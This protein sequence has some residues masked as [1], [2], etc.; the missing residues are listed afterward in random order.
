MFRRPSL[1][2]IPRLG[3]LLWLRLALVLPGSAQTIVI[4]EVHYDPPEPTVRAEFVELHNPSTQSIPLAGWQLSGGIQFLFPNEARLE[5]GGF[6]VIGEHPATLAQ[7]WNVSAL[8]PWSGKLA[9]S[10]DSIELR[11]PTGRLVD[12]VDYQPGF[13]WP[14][15]GTDPGLS[16]ERIHPDLDGNLAG[17]WRASV[18]G[19]TT[20]T[21][22]N[23]VVEAGSEWRYRKGTPDAAA[24]V[25]Q[26]RTPDFSDSDW[27]PARLPIGYDA[28]VSFGTTLADMRGN[29]SSF[30]LRKSFEISD[31]SGISALE[32]H[33]LY[34]DGFKLWLNG[35]PLL[36]L[37]L[38]SREV[39]LSATAAGTRESN[40]YESLSVPLPAGLLRDGPNLLAVQ[41]HNV[42]LANSTDCFFDARVVT[43][44]GPTG[45]GPTP[46][47]TNL[48]YATNAPPAIRQVQH[49]PTQPRSGAPVTLS[50]RITDPDG[51]K[52]VTLAY[53]VV[54]PGNY[55]ELQDPDFETSWTFLPMLDD[56][57]GGDATA[58]D[59]L[60]TA[61]I[62]PPAQLH[63]TLV[64]YRI[65]ASDTHDQQVRVPYPDDPQPN[66]AYF[67]YDGAPAWSGSIRPGTTGTLGRTFTVSSNEMNRLP[68]VHL[69]A[70]R[71]A[72][73]ESTW[74][75]RYGGDAYLWNGTLVYDGQV[76]DHVRYR[77][78]GGVWRY[79]MT[80][81]MWKFDF[82]RGHSF[83]ARDDWGRRFPASWTKLNLGAS[84]QQ[85]DYNHRGEQGMFES[86]GFRIF[87]LAGVPAMNS[88][89]VQFRVID[90]AA[91]AIPGNQFEGDFWG[92]YLMLEQPDGRFLDSHDLPDGNLYKM[93]GGTG[94]LNNVGPD[95]PLDKS[96]LNQFL[97]A[98]SAADESWWR[99]HFE[100]TQFLG[101]QTV[102]QAI[103]HYDICYDK[104]FFY[105]LN[106]V[107]QRW[108]VIPW[109]LDLSWADN[110]FDPGCG[111]VD[112]IKQR[113]LPNPSRFPRVWR[114]WQNRIREFR[115]LFWNSDE[116]W[117]LIDEQAGRLRGPAP[118]GTPTVLDADRAQWDYN[119]KMVDPTYSSSPNSKAGHGR[120][121]R[122]PNYPESEVSRDFEGCLTLM[123]RYVGFR[124]TN[125][126]AQAR[127][128]D[129][130]A[131]DPALPPRPRLAY[132]GTPG[133]PV[134]ALRF[135]CS[136]P[137]SGPAIATTRWRIGAIT[138]PSLSGP[139]WQATEPWKYEITPVWESGP[140]DGFSPQTDI[141]PGALRVGET[142]RARVQFEDAEGRT[143][144][145]SEPIEFVAGPPDTAAALAASL[146]VTELMFHAP[147]GA[148]NDFLELYNAGDIP[149][150]L[151]GAT[152]SQ[153]IE[154]T[155]PT[156]AQLAPR[157][158]AL[159]SRASPTGNFAGFRT[160][161]GL[162]STVPIFGPYSGNFSDA[163]ETI[164][165]RDA[166]GGTDLIS[167]TYSDGR[168]WPIP[169]DGAGHSLV[170]RIDFGSAASGALDFGGN[171]RASA[172]ILGS[173]GRAD[174]EPDTSLV[175]NE[176]VAH[177]DFLSEFD[178]NDWV[179]LYNRSNTPITL[180]P[181]WFLSDN[182]DNLR[183][184]QIPAGT[185][186]PARGWVVFDEVTGFNHPTGTGFGFDK[187]GEAAFLSH[188]PPGGPGR[189]V[190]AV[191]FKGQENEWALARIPDGGPSW[192][193]TI[194]RT[195]RAANAALLPRVVISELQYHEG[196]LPT[197]RV[198]AQFLEFLEIHNATAQRAELFNTNAV[199]R[200][201]G[202]VTF[203]F[204]LV[205]F[206]RP[207]ERLIVVSF[208][209]ATNPSLLAGFRA[210]FQ[211]PTSI[212]ILGPYQ[213][214][215]DNDA[216]RIA[217]ERAQ[218]PDL[219]GEP[220][221]WVIVDEVTYFDRDPWPGGADGVG[222]SYQRRSA[223]APGN[224]SSNWFASAPTPGA[225][226]PSSSLDTD[227][228]SLP[229]A[230]ETA[231]GLNPRDPSDAL[232]DADGDGLS[233][234]AEYQA[235]THPRD[236]LSALSLTL[237]LA[238]PPAT[239]L[240]LS[241]LA[242]S[243]R[244]YVIE[245]RDLGTPGSSWSTIHLVPQGSDT[246]KITVP[247]P[248]QL[249][250]PGRLH[251]VRLL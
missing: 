46:G 122:W 204:P 32:I 162:A 85:G 197:N 171:W 174:P 14:T 228:D 134:N 222:A 173:P 177:T 25:P 189:V 105:Y 166:A 48:V 224:D 1:G 41:V 237:T 144:A 241:F 205:T 59:N 152:F 54:R 208:D 213:G 153:G 200:L 79:A 36:D 111:G 191:T 58:N 8:G 193:Q 28:S 120:F 129:L 51:V 198:P 6:L 211:I 124:A 242:V 18:S 219:P 113:L 47:R 231:H 169:T 159:L 130:L 63:R 43:V 117:R 220:I 80:K 236:P 176:L 84:I 65:T 230:W 181:G 233:N 245:E 141:P 93:E 67:V 110:M 73:E 187:A 183:R 194:P 26:W 218:A 52:S 34:D 50:A 86:T 147:G 30:L 143:S 35:Q 13:P 102:V 29:Y 106:P 214:R 154:F 128:L 55:L 66:F 244:G 140:I 206:L 157:S 131:D 185:T 114:Q 68:A 168:G 40:A 127:A 235:G 136:P 142:Y 53:Q 179:E 112:R 167:F 31:P 4:N 216:D 234:L 5:P 91:E 221:S 70:K 12:R 90:D 115:D 126:A 44:R 101:Y 33:A 78:R 238:P 82:H 72:V 49:S 16:I 217:L 96:D 133:F 201:N 74:T 188:F 27:A 138:R 71:Q 104:N 149:L 97:A 232:L 240:E 175:L 38:P 20:A 61:T 11:D 243:G 69:I 137:T 7:R 116:A 161:Y 150:P 248:I 10:G 60:F 207:D 202:G 229:D 39:P 135:H 45:Q 37:N 148:T 186:I 57:S 178:S 172:E 145:W 239:S 98:Y 223:T 180:G 15:V 156:G 182:P 199:W 158:Y 250:A 249:N 226:P 163:G 225:P 165:L 192:D 195:P 251:R 103:H 99:D 215:L 107:T 203:D 94:E 76:Y 88:A 81:N 146:R 212:Q 125:T 21:T 83:Q 108:S 209:P 64:R 160:F 77:A 109:D 170:P 75:R 17:H 118:A 190:D 227:N 23:V 210:T 19:G 246:R 9:N 3:I 56:G 92:V 42:A 164:A 100:I 123:K 121:Y 247:L 2:A 24:L 62:P 151:A 22:R 155:F 184:W 89:F 139:A 196:G 119:P 95:G 132:A 87:E